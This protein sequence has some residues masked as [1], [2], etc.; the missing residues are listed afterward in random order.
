[1]WQKAEVFRK[2]SLFFREQQ[3]N[4][5][6]L[7]NQEKGG[8]ACF[9]HVNGL[10]LYR[11]FGGT[12]LGAIWS[13]VSFSDTL[14]YRHINHRPLYLQKTA[15]LPELKILSFSRQKQLMS[16]GLSRSTLTTIKSEW[17]K[18]LGTK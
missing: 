14:T 5:G 12:K 17:E 6:H 3:I 4:H 13:S 11:T 10:H 2:V 16:K 1:M 7:G 9:A 18:E 8:E 15:F